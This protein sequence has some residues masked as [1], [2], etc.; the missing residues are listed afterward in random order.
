VVDDVDVVELDP[1]PLLR[2]P[3]P[4]LPLLLLPLA[5][6]GAHAGEPGTVGP[7]FCATGG[8]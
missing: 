6:F 4:L 3:E 2:K 7:Q 8:R 5:W 1:P